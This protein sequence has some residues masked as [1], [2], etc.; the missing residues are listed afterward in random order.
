MIPPEPTQYPEA[1]GLAGQHPA[2]QRRYPRDPANFIVRATCFGGDCPLGYLRGLRAVSRA[3]API[4]RP[5]SA[6]TFVEK[7]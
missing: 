7:R 2:P 5:M 1:T 4:L 3:W 6:P